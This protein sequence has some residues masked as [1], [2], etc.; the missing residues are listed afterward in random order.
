M[1]ELF[2]ENEYIEAWL[3]D[4]I[5]EAMYKP[6]LRE[7]DLAITKQVVKD[8]LEASK[9]V[10][11]PLFI[12]MNKVVD[13]DQASR[14]YLSDGD[15]IKYLNATAIMVKNQVT[16]FLANIFIRFNTPKIPTKFF[17]KKEDALRWL[18]QFKY[19]N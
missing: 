7:I 9:G 17:T 15:G 3:V 10:S 8:R 4:G 14:E 5:I 18:E 13:V 12:D 6:G 11:R 19:M 16:K 1:R 2:H